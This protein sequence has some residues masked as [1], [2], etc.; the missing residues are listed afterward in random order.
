MVSKNIPLKLDFRSGLPIY[1]QI[2][3]QIRQMIASDELKLGD[4]LPTVR[5]LATDLRINWNTVAR[6]YKLLD[7]AGLISTQ[8]GRGTYIWEQP[9][10]A[11]TQALRHQT[12]EALTHRYINEAVR[13]GSSPTEIE[14]ILN[15]SLKAWKSDELS[16]QTD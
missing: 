6:A 7:E 14:A 12:L 9:S 10:D 2:M 11:T 4:Q 8:Q 16:D 1:V 5:Q 3:D 15:K 13:L